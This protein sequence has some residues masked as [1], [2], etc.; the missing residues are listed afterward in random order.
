MRTGPCAAFILFATVAASAQVVPIRVTI[1]NLGATNGSALSPFTVG[2]HN[3]AWDPFDTGA[4][5]NLGIRNI[6]ELGDGGVYLAE[7]AAAQPQGVSG[8]VT[9]TT[10]AFGSGIFLPGGSGSMEFKIDVGVNRFFS[11]GSMVMPSNDRFVANDETIVLFDSSGQLVTSSITLMGSDIW[12]AGTELDELFGAAFI[13][14][15]HA[16][17]HTPQNGVIKLNSDFGVW[18]GATTPAGYAFNVTP[19]VG[20]PVARITFTVI[21]APGAVVLLAMGATVLL[22]RRR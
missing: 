12:D 10:G 19:S 8:V 17:E 13:Q 2:F 18:A 4:E 3:G 22:A 20:S 16:K 9:A 21:P 5:A 1:E 15:Q 6:A 14:G 11:F 7:F